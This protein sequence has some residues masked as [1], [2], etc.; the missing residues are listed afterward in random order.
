MGGWN[1]VYTTQGLALLSRLAPGGTL[2]ITRAAAGTGTV[3]E[4]DLVR[5]TS[6]TGERQN[7]SFQTPTYPEQ[8]TCKLPTYIANEGLTAGYTV[9]QIGFYA[10]D[11]NGK[12]ILYFIAQSTNGTAIPSESEMVGY[13]AT[14]VFYFKYGQAD[15]VTVIVDPTNAVTID[16]LNEVRIIAEQGVSEQKFGKVVVIDDTANVPFAGLSVYGKSTQDGTPTPSAPIDIESIAESGSIDVDVYGKN[17]FKVEPATANGVTLEKRGDFYVLNGTATGSY[18]FQTKI[19]YLPA[20]TYSISA[21]NP[22]NNG[23]YLAI[24]DVYSS[25]KNVALVAFDNANNS[26]NSMELP[27]ST[28]YICRIRIESGV[29]YN[30]YKIQPQLELN[31]KATDY[32]PYTKQSATIS[33]PNGLRGIAVASGGNYKDTQNNSWICDELDLVRGVYIQR[34]ASVDLSTLTWNSYSSVDDVA[35]AWWQSAINGMKYVVTN[36]ELGAALAENYSIRVANGMSRAT[37]GQFAVDTNNIKVN[38]GSTTEKPEGMMLYCLETPIET[39]LNVAVLDSNNPVTTVFNNAGAEMMVD[40]IRIVNE[41]AFKMVTDITP[42]K[43]GAAYTPFVVSAT[44][45]A[46]GWVDG[47]QTVAVEGVKVTS[48]G[49]LYSAPAATADQDKAFNNAQL[50]VTAQTTGSLTVTCRGTVP[51]ID[52]PIEV[53]VRN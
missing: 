1:G 31:S 40:C 24:V 13:T 29:V 42:A 6:V 50:K 4:T 18:N 33:T 16:M 53:E 9:H 30:N 47:V 17:L 7:M 44:L 46:A 19:G 25:L 39:P 32:E 45:T 15:E 21:N 5:Q 48:C 23:I 41:N 38:N 22:T 35:N 49:D 14:W 2:N 8:G 26:K 34:I 10:A 3:N 36:A 20:G 12:E 43:I 11:S 28:D 51:A 27:E 52:L 37:T